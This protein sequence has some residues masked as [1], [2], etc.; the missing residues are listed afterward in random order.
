MT[1][2]RLLTRVKPSV[3]LEVARCSSTVLAPIPLARQ[4]PLARVKPSVDLEGAGFRSSVPTL[5]PLTGKRLL[6][7]VG[8]SVSC[9]RTWRRKELPALLIIAPV[10]VIRHG[11]GAR[12]VRD[13]KLRDGRL[14]FI[15]AQFFFPFSFDFALLSTFRFVESRSR[16]RVC[17]IG[18]Y[19]RVVARGW[20]CRHGLTVV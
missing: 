13:T 12:R 5:F 16:V 10:S 9:Q 19:W 8:A 2:K 6:A 18:G 14:Y 3:L 17:V 7:R 4:Q 15:G 20:H 11:C 1:G